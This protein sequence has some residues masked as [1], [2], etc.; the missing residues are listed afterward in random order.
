MLLILFV[1]GKLVCQTQSKIWYFDGKK[2]DF[3]SGTP[4]VQTHFSSA[5]SQDGAN[6]VYGPLSALFI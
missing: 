3:S 5:A 6:G 1:F 4:V 2:V